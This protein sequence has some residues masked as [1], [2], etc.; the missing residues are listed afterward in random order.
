MNSDAVTTLRK[1]FFF[2]ILKKKLYSFNPIKGI[3]NFQNFDPQKW[4]LGVNHFENNFK[5]LKA[6]LK[7]ILHVKG[8]EGI[9]NFK[10]TF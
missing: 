8:S 4:S 7:K 1:L 5:N 3:I 10:D 2:T 6:L 9:L